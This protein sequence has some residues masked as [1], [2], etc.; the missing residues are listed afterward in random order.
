M[1]SSR[2]RYAR[3][4]GSSRWAPV[5][6]SVRRARSVRFTVPR[7]LKN[8]PTKGIRSSRRRGRTAS[9]SRSPVSP[10]SCATLS[11]DA[12]RRSRGQPIVSVLATV[13][14]LS[15]ASYATS[16]SRTV[17]QRNSPTEPTLRTYGETPRAA[18]GLVQMRHCGYSPASAPGQSSGR[19]R[20]GSRNV[21]PSA[22]PSS[23]CVTCTP[24]PW[25]RQPENFRQSKRST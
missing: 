11:R 12:L 20:S 3:T 4:T 25:S 5:L 1:S 21:S 6:C 18:T 23:T 9:I 7:S 17:A 14:R 10:R 16:R 19:W 15:V 8:S 2:A 13:E 24:S 22:T